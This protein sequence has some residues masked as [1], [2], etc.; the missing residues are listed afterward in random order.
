VFTPDPIVRLQ[1]YPDLLAGFMGK[2]LGKKWRKGVGES[3]GEGG[4]R[5]MNEGRKGW[6][7]SGSG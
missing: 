4:E 6:N 5:T 3:N 7:G 1:H 2:V